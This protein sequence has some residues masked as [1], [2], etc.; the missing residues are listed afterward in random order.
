MPSRGRRRSPSTNFFTSRA[1]VE[2]IGAS[3]PAV[4]PPSVTASMLDASTLPAS[5]ST[6]L[7]ARKARFAKASTSAGVMWAICVSVVGIGGTAGRS[8]RKELGEQE[9]LHDRGYRISPAAP[10]GPPRRAVPPSPMSRRWT[11]QSMRRSSRR[12]CAEPAE[13]VHDCVHADDV[14]IDVD[15]QVA[16]DAVHQCEKR[17]AGCQGCRRRGRRREPRD[18]GRGVVVACSRRTEPKADGRG[19]DRRVGAQNEGAAARQRS[20]LLLRRARR[21]RNGKS[22]RY[23]EHNG[24]EQ[25]PRAS[26]G[27]RRNGTRC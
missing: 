3:V 11:A 20:G 27:F 1:S 22:C 25:R 12:R 15:V 24:Q 17:F 23:A 6:A 16:A 7:L 26:R 14:R 8:G 9:I 2:S 4:P 19:S 10:P 21:T 5:A 18:T 13:R